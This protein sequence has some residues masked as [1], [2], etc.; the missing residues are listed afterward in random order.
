VSARRLLAPRTALSVA[1]AIAVLALF[2]TRRLPTVAPG[3]AS[4]APAAEPAS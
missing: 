1:A 3:V 2:P 4:A